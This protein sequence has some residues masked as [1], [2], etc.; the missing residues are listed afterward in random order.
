MKTKEHSG[1][2]NASRIH[3]RETALGASRFPYTTLRIPLP[4]HF[5]TFK[6]LNPRYLEPNYLALS[7]LPSRM[8][9]LEMGNPL[10]ESSINA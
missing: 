4:S 5:V 1:K 7:T 10:T 8:K 6:E 3:S 9:Q 2:I